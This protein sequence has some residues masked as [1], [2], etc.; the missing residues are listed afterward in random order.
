MIN[1]SRVRNVLEERLSF[2][3]DCLDE[4]T[5]VEL[6]KED[7]G[8]EELRAKAIVDEIVYGGYNGMADA[9]AMSMILDIAGALK[10]TIERH[11]LGRVCAYILA[12]NG[13]E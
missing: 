11:L 1:E 4:R 9:C 7:I 8:Q 12:I 5:G 13:M 10:I 3:T 2:I 6:G